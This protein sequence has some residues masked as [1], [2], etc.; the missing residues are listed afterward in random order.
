MNQNMI[1][2]AIQF[3]G[4]A[5]MYIIVGAALGVAIVAIAEMFGGGME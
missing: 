5:S 1:F 3:A 2:A 4:N